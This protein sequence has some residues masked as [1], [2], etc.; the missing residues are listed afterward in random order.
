M[1]KKF[2]LVPLTEPMQ[3][4]IFCPDHGTRVVEFSADG[5]LKGDPCICKSGEVIPM[6]QLQMTIGTFKNC[7]WTVSVRGPLP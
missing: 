6:H 1:T 4:E 2:F 7:R 3:L 5:K